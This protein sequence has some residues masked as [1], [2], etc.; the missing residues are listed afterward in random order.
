VAMPLRVMIT[1]TA[2]TPSVDAVLELI[3]REE[4]L[5]R[6]DRGLASFS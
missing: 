5:A 4:V 2:Q 6:M 1:G 3:G